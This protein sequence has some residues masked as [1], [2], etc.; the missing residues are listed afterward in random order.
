LE[1]EPFRLPT[2]EAYLER[3]ANGYDLCATSDLF[4]QG[5]RTVLFRLPYQNTLFE[6]FVFYHS[7]LSDIYNISI[8]LKTQVMMMGDD[9]EN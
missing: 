8:T 9:C 4:K 6:L 2:H 3:F 1:Q 5:L 7:N